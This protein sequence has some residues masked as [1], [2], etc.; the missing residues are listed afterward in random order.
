MAAFCTNNEEVPNEIKDC[1]GHSLRG[2][3]SAEAFGLST[4]SRNVAIRHAQSGVL[5]TELK[6]LRRAVR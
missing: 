1:V 6:R 4:N 5:F 3:R 2:C